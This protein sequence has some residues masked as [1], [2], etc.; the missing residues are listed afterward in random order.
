MTL[1]QLSERF[2]LSQSGIANI[3]NG[4]RQ[5]R[6]SKVKHWTPEQD[7]KMK[8]AIERGAKHKEVAKIVGKSVHAV[9]S[10]AAYLGVTSKWRLSA[11]TERNDG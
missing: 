1:K 11:A 7:I 9:A 3:C 8:E 10:H 2:G 5:S 4:R 6:P